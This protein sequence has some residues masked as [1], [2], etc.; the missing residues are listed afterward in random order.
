MSP[1]LLRVVVVE[2]HPMVRE[3]IVEALAAEPDLK[4]VGQ[5]G[6]GLAAV[7][8]TLRLCPD[9]VVMD[10]FLP[11]QGGVE[12]IHQIKAQ[13]PEVMVLAL[14]SATDE[15][16]F[17][18]ALQ[19]GASGYLVKDSERR[20][21]LK[22]VRD[23]ARGETAIA[24]RM[25]GKLVAHLNRAAGSGPEPLS[26]REREILRLVGEGATNQEI[27]AR[28]QVGGSTVRTHMQHIL[29]KLGLENRNQAVLYAIR[30]GLAGPPN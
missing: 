13:R 25:V 6:D 4:V 23:V 19:A 7:G 26:E 28:L 1:P 11:L 5:A 27:A 9:V 16:L 22:A 30:T 10:L 20:A 15:A 8:E 14:T 21:L 12:A 3:A 18:A 2:D 17:L 24:P 29:E